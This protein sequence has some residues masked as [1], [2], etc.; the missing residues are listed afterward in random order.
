M[1]KNILLW[2]VIAMVLMS[3][4]DNFTTGQ[5]GR[6]TEVDYSTFLAE[7]KQGNVAAVRISGDTITGET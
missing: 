7:V 4:F 5:S 2:L 6:T 3:V 1:T